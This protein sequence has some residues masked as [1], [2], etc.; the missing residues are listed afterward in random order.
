MPG[1]DNIYVL[2]DRA[3]EN[4]LRPFM[5]HKNDVVPLR[6]TTDLA[7][8]P[9]SVINRHAKDFELIHIG[10]V[11]CETLQ[12]VPMQPRLVATALDLVRKDQ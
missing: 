9:E 1:F 10:Q 11:D 12:L 3:A 7:N 4:A 6:E 2:Y 5:I 8:N